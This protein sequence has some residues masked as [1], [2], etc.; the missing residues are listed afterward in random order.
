PGFVR[1]S[2]LAERPYPLLME[3]EPVAR[4]IFRALMK[5]R[6]R[7]V[8]DR[9]YRLLVALWRLIPQWLWEHLPIKN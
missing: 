6:R 7:V 5:G 4:A 1:T 9:R 3:V 2:L 8:I